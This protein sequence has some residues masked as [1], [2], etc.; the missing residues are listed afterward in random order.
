MKA[1]ALIALALGLLTA[2]ALAAPAVAGGG[3]KT[4]VTIQAES[5][6]FFGFVKSSNPDKCANG[7]KVKLYKQT[8]SEQDPKSDQKI[9]S[10]IAQPNG[11]GFMWSTGNTGSHGGHFYARAGKV[12]GCKADNSPTIKAQK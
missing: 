2:V 8:G 1:R 6:G 4:R 10:D 12:K 9:G 7:R 3:A 5:G 11:D